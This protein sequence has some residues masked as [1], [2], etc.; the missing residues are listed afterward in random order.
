MTADAST[1]PVPV[2]LTVHAPGIPLA[3][4]AR[5]ASLPGQV[6]G[7]AR[8]EANLHG[9]GRT[10]RGLAASLNGPVLVTAV[11]GQMSNA[12]LIKLASASLDALGIKVPAQG[13]TAL[14]CLG[15]AGSFSNGVARLHTIALE[16]THLSLQGAGQ[17]DL[18]RETVAL[19]LNPLA[20]VSGSPVSVPVVVEGPFHAISGRLDADAFHKL[21]L[22]FDAWFGGDRQTACADAGLVPGRAPGQ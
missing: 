9:I 8:I 11:G 7:T 22:L 4:L 10:V 15:V 2:S 17:V 14:R 3:L 19:R 1:S 20:Q 12:V 18:G 5:Y 13:E 21:G 16:T 6:S